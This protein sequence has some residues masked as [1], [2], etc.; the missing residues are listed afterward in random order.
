MGW[1]PQS[2]AIFELLHSRTWRKI[3]NRKWVVKPRCRENV[4][5]DGSP[6]N[7][8]HPRKIEIATNVAFVANFPLSFPDRRLGRGFP[9]AERCS[10]RSDACDTPHRSTA[11]AAASVGRPFA[12]QV[13]FG[14]SVGASVCGKG[15]SVRA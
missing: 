13:R 11:S 5:A 15:S 1:T 7:L 8:G 3:R 2:S 10:C 9:R 14:P 4:A 12:R 6:T